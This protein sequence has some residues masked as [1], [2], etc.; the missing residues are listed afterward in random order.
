VDLNETRAARDEKQS[1]IDAL[2]ARGEELIALAAET[3]LLAKEPQAKAD[4]LLA[5]VAEI[6]TRANQFEDEAIVTEMKLNSLGDEYDA[7]TTEIARL[8]GEAG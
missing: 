5:E 3:R 4:V 1:E 2:A 8:E 6:E 7:L